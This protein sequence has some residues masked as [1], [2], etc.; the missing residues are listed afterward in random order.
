MYS[1]KLFKDQSENKII[2]NKYIPFAPFYHGFQYH[3][4]MNY[5]Q[6]NKKKIYSRALFH[7][8]AELKKLSNF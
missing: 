5:K 1:Y 3:R 2:N 6:T 7:H 8:Y 4:L